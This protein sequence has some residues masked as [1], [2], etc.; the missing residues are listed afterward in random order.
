M[1]YDN[2]ESG[3]IAE[4]FKEWARRGQEIG[5]K[6][7]DNPITFKEYSERASETAK[8]PMDKWDVYLPIAL[9]GE[10]GELANKVKKIIRDD[11]GVIS[12]EAKSMLLAELGD[13]LWYCSEYAKH[14]DSSLELVAQANLNKLA[15][16]S[17][18]NVIHGSGDKR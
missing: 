13:I 12:F 2:D 1:P 17:A 10:A 11:G 3:Q 8:Y 4:A 18:R 16:R 6:L 7:D 14:L 5:G 15:S 9:C